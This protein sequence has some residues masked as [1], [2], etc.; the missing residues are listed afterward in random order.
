[1]YFT[2][3]SW[4]SPIHVWT[5]TRSNLVW[6]CP[7]IPALRRSISSSTT[8]SPRSFALCITCHRKRNMM[9]KG[10]LL[11]AIDV[12][13][14]AWSL[15]KS[16]AEPR[17][18]QNPI[19][20]WPAEYEL[21]CWVWLLLPDHWLKHVARLDRPELLLTSFLIS[22][23]CSRDCTRRWASTE[24][25]ECGRWWRCPGFWYDLFVVQ[26]MLY[27]GSP[28]TSRAIIVLSLRTHMIDLWLMPCWL[29]AHYI[30]YT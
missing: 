18:S 22:F 21:N 16:M 8:Q 17:S 10:C 1:M 26:C 30:Q 5:S 28:S 11:G 15:E 3:P 23:Q 12:I 7:R 25:L 6:H 9:C 19:N 24:V 13:L 4:S 29:G 20:V 2:K 14:Q 27:M